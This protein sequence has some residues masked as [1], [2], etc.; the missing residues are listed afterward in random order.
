MVRTSR[1]LGPARPKGWVCQNPITSPRRSSL[2]KTHDQSNST[3][4][5]SPCRRWQSRPSQMAPFRLP[6]R[7]PLSSRLY[8]FRF[9]G[10]TFRLSATS[11]P[12]RLKLVVVFHEALLSHRD[13]SARRPR[14]LNDADKT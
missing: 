6:T 7:T 11:S 9:P 4:D 5:A 10:R 8:V 13:E 2:A 14:L 1:R 12:P 3:L